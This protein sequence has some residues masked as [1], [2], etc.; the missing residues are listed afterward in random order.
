M[1]TSDHKPVIEKMYE[2]Q[3]G[4]G[5]QLANLSPPM[6]LQRSAYFLSITSG[7][8]HNKDTSSDFGVNFRQGKKNSEF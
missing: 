7:I 3:T 5:E 2:A 6:L 8:N 1:C 4:N